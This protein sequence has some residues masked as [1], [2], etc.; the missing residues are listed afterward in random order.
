M[1]GG[2]MRL[3]PAAICCHHGLGRCYIRWIFRRG[4]G[5]ISPAVVLAGTSPLHTPHSPT[6][7]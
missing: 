7:Y 2:T 4:N 3:S 1:T 6:P 5:Y